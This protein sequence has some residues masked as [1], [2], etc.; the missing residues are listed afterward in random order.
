MYNQKIL[1]GK[2][3]K[4]LNVLLFKLRQLRIKPSTAC[5]LVDAFVGS[6]L[7]YGSEIWGI[8]KSKEIE[9][10]HLKFLKY[11]LCLK[12]STSNMAVFVELSRFPLYISRCVHVIK[13]WIKLM[14]SDN[15][16]IKELCLDMM[17]NVNRGLKIGQAQVKM[18]LDMYGFSHIWLTQHVR[19]LENFHIVFN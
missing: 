6:I 2:G 14:K 15:V 10:I 3:L 5:Q 4:A 11:I 12:A 18:L 9:R 19:N 7:S 16:L 17:A 1:D 8:T 13:Y